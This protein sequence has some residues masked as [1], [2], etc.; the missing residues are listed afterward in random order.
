MVFVDA[1]LDTSLSYYSGA[2]RTAHKLIQRAAQ[3]LGQR[4]RRHQ[5]RHLEPALEPV[6]GRRRHI[7]LAAQLRLAQPLG[8][9]PPADVIA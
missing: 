1:I 4:H 3:R 5:R 2:G 6:D 8:L 9:A 7:A